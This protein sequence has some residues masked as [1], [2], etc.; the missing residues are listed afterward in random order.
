M[1][2][3]RK[4]FNSLETLPDKT[5]VVG[6]TQWD[7][8]VPH[9]TVVNVGYNFDFSPWYHR[10]IDEV[11]SACQQ[12]IMHCLRT[13]DGSYSART[14]RSCC[15]NGLDHYFDYLLLLT[16]VLKRHIRLTDIDRDAVDQFIQYLG[17]SDIGNI[18]Q[19]NRYTHVKIVLRGLVERGFI[20]QARLFPKNPYPN[21]KRQSKPSKALSSQERNQLSQA[22]RK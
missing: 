19:L 3:P 22:L 16:V 13:H 10:G 18:T 12:Q 11:V 7:L 14:L 21:I 5:G 15:D 9:N 6:A 8:L 17:Q 20:K 2:K 4:L 1:A